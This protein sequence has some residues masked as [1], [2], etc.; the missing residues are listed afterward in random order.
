[1]TIDMTN[2]SAVLQAKINALSGTSEFK[3]LL[4]LAKA[5]EAAAGN[6]TVSEVLATGTAQVGSVNTAGANQVQAVNNAAAAKIAAINALDAVLKSGGVMTGPLTTTALSAATLTADAA[7]PSFYWRESDAPTSGKTWEANVENQ[8]L[9]FRIWNEAMSAYTSFLRFVRNGVASIYVMFA[10]AVRAQVVPLTDG[11]TITPDFNAGNVFSVTLGGN[12]TLANPL[13]L[14]TDH[15]GGSIIIR[16]DGT[17][18]RQL[19]YGSSWKFVT[20]IIPPLSTGANAVDRLVYS[21]V[22]PTEIH[23]QLLPGFR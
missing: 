1:M 16:Q 22:S 3:D 23:C 18:N 20:G 17:G 19:S 13:N 5:I 12:R 7:S 2:L 4:L 6:A 10:T 8:M 9:A 15:Q 21:V 11:A 14:T